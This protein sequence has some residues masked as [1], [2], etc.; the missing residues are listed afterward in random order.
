MEDIL[1]YELSNADKKLLVLGKSKNKT[2][3]NI[4]NKDK[5]ETIDMKNEY[6][7]L[8]DKLSINNNSINEINKTIIEAK[9]QAKSYEDMLY[10]TPN[11]KTID[12]CQ[13]K[14]NAL[15]DEIKE[16]EDKEY[17]IMVEN[18]KYESN[19]KDIK[20][21]VSALKKEYDTNIKEYKS[22]EAI[23][24]NEIDMLNKKRTEIA[25]KLSADS[26][27]EYNELKER[28]GYGMCKIEK[29]VCSGCSIE[30]PVSTIREAGQHKKLIKCPSCGRLL[31]MD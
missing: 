23:V 18:D 28:Y 19:I 9:K 6:N 26:L 4:D 17:N 13:K 5:N 12:A 14:I 22:E 27:K 21:S 11:L 1:L 31:F 7:K 29:G 16:N 3:K 15:K 10:N 2:V 30:L 20:N 24:K 25:G 8:K